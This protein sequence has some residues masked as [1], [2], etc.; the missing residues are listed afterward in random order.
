MVMFDSQFLSLKEGAAFAHVSKRTLKRW[1]AAGLPAHQP[2]SGGKILLIVSELEQF[3]IRRTRPQ[4]AL[5]RLVNDVMH[6]LTDGRRSRHGPN[7]TQTKRPSGLGGAR[8]GHGNK[9]TQ[10]L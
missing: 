7:A 4:P 1:L 8:N 3:I 6:E 10:G 9:R 2:I 5:D